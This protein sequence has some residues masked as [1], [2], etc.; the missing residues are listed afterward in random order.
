MRQKV[1]KEAGEYRWLAD[2]TGGK[3]VL[4]VLKSLT[5]VISRFPGVKID[6]LAMEEGDLRLHGTAPSF[7]KVDQLKQRLNRTGLFKD[8]RMVSARMDKKEKAVK[9]NFAMERK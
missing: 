7:E 1:E 6:D 5:A 3:T 2:V 4:D 9:F 8:V